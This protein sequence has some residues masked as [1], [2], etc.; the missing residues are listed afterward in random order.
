MKGTR[1]DRLDDLARDRAAAYVLGSLSL[2]ER[3]ELEAHL[4]ACDLCR[5]EVESL[6]SVLGDLAALAPAMSP[7]PALKER[8]LARVRESEPSVTQPW[9]QWL[10]ATSEAGLTLVR[11]G[12]G[13]WEPSGVDGVEIRRLFLDRENDRATMLVRMAPGTSY[14]AHVHGGAEE[15][16]VLQGDL[17]VAGTRMVAGDY[18]RATSGSLHGI[19]STVGGCLLFIVSSLHDELSQEARV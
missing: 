2:E 12:E 10:P 11:A 15:C 13:A 8:L 7:P 17:D 16:Y 14:P 5:R 9:K 18:Q 4:R 6:E 3:A 19:Q 1:H